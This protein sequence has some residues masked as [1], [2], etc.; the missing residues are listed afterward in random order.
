M[1]TFSKLQDPIKTW[2]LVKEERSGSKKWDVK[3]KA[4]K[5]EC[6][7]QRRWW[8]LCSVFE[9]VKVSVDKW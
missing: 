2:A 5:V 7:E 1:C 9:A 4:L 3:G 8:N 6:K